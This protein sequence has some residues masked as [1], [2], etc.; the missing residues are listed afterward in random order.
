M[1]RPLCRPFLALGSG[2]WDPN[3]QMPDLPELGVDGYFE[4]VP[5]ADASYQWYLDGQKDLSE[6][7]TTWSPAKW[8]A[9]YLENEKEYGPSELPCSVEEMLNR[10]CN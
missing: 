5:Y 3:T 10:V 2:Q 6:S 9:I 4:N 7:L 8:D 1:H